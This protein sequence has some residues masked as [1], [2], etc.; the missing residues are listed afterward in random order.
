MFMMDLPFEPRFDDAKEDERCLYERG[1]K[2]Y[3]EGQFEPPNCMP[4][5]DGVDYYWLGYMVTKT[6]QRMRY[7]RYEDLVSFQEILRPN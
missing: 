2:A 1:I 3:L 4:S 5:T 6:N 7:N